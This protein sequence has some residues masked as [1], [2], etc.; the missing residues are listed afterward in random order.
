MLDTAEL[1]MAG[2]MSQMG[3]ALLVTVTTKPCAAIHKAEAGRPFE[4]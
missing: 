1:G 4:A 2:M 3:Q